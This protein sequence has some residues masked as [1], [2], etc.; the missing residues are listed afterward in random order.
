MASEGGP[1][2]GSDGGLC[3]G[4]F[5][6]ESPVEHSLTLL[7]PYQ[8]SGRRAKWADHLASCVA[9]KI[10]GARGSESQAPLTLNWQ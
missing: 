3:R 7:S 10:D 2:E 8:G 5:L 4:G 6:G 9:T 1:R